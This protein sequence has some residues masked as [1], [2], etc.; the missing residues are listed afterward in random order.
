MKTFAH[1]PRYVQIR[2]HIRCQVQSGRFAI[3]AKI[4]T[5]PELIKQFNV[6][7]IT[8][9]NAVRDLAKEGILTRDNRGTFVLA[10]RTNQSFDALAGLL[11]PSHGHVWAQMTQNLIQKLQSAGYYSLVV[12]PTLPH[13]DESIED[14][15]DTLLAK[16]F[17]LLL[18]DGVS[19]FPFD[20]L[21]EHAPSIAK[22]VFFFRLETDLRFPSAP[23]VLSDFE[24]GGYI[25]IR[26]L[27]EHG[28]RRILLYTHPV[29]PIGPFSYHQILIGGR[30]AV[31][32]T[33]L[34]PDAVLESLEHRP[35]AAANSRRLVERLSQPTR[36]TAVFVFQDHYA[37][38]VFR[39]A[40]QLGVVIPRDLSVIGYYNTPWTQDLGV[41]LTSISIEEEAIVNAVRSIIMAP[42]QSGDRTIW[43]KPKLVVRASTESRSVSSP[44]SQVH[45][46]SR[47]D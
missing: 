41:P 39:S 21:A 27:L 35:D 26:H 1:A 20:V 14:R 9:T 19:T 8:V 30:R 11:L 37:A 25:A 29:S 10:P 24:H 6:S 16:R 43:I 31:Q 15:L 40:H 42:L 44:I 45:P 47:S 33:G 13:P 36:P 17:A 46:T 3:G 18:V 23:R 7:R 22:L 12:D 34:N 28:H 5:E 38:D 2:E 4:P 32:E